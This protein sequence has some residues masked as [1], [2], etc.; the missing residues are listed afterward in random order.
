MTDEEFV[1]IPLEDKDEM[2]RRAALLEYYKPGG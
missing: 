2:R 1:K